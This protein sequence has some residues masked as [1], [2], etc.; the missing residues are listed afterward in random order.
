MLNNK[1][2]KNKE[3]K[4]KA[5]N[6]VKSLSVRVIAFVITVSF[7][8][9]SG[10][11]GLYAKM[12]SSDTL[13][14]TATENTGITAQLGEELKRKN[15][16]QP[17]K[18][19]KRIGILTG[20]GPAS[21][22]NEVIYS[23]IEEAQ[24]QGGIE[25]IA[26]WEG[27]KGLVDDKLAGQA[28]P[29]T[30]EEVEPE[31]HKG[32]TVI[33]TSRENPYDKKAAEKGL[34]LPEKLWANIQKLGLDALI[35]CGGDDSQGASYQLQQQHPDFLVIGLPKTMDNDIN[36][37]KDA[38]S[39]GF[40]TFVQAAA[41]ALERGKRDAQSTN[42]VLVTGIFG[43][44]A[45]HVAV[46]AAA[47]AKITRTLIPE[48]G[49]L[50]LE[51]L[52]QDVKE[53]Y[54]K[55]K[56][57]VV[58]VAE[59]VSINKYYK[60]NAAILDKAFA[61]DEHAMVAF[62]RAARGEK[63]DSYGNPYLEGAEIIIAAVLEANGLSISRAGKIDYLFRSEDVSPKDR[64]MCNLLGRAAVNNLIEGNNNR[65][66]YVDT[67]GALES[68]PFAKKVGGRTFDIEEHKEVYL[69]AN[70]ALL[71][72]YLNDGGSSE[73]PSEDSI[74]SAQP[75]LNF[76]NVAEVNNALRGILEVGEGGVRIIDDAR[77]RGEL[78]DKLVYDAT[79]NNDP[80][81]VKLCRQL[82]RDTASAQGAILSSL[83]S[84]YVAKAKDKRQYT[85]PAINI[86][87]MAYNTARPVFTSAVANNVGPFILEIAKSEIGY[88]AQR[89]A[90][91]TTSI[92]AAAIKEGY[93]GPVYLQGD[94]FQISAD[95]YYGNA[96]K[97]IEANPEKAKSDI[98][99]MIREAVAAGFY[100]I[101]LDMST[102][103]DWSKPTANE[104]QKNNY[105]E[106]AL[107]TAFVRDL[108]REFGLDK[109]GIVVN[110]G[111]E[112]GEIGM[113]LDKG[114]QLNSSVEDLRAFMNGY[115][116]ELKA[117]GQQIGYELKPVTKIAVQTG[118]KHGGV[119]DAQGK[120]TKAMVSFNTLAETGNVARE[121]FGLAGVVQHGAS[122]LP[123]DYFTVFAGKPVPEG[124]SVDETLLNEA[125]KTVLGTNPVAEV[126]LATA[127]QDTIMEHEQFP[128]ALLAQIWDYIL[129]KI[130][131]KE[132]EGKDPN[133]VFVDN[134]KNAWGSFK[135][136]L[137]NLPDDIQEAFRNSLEAQF[138]T[139]FINLGVRDSHPIIAQASLSQLII[140]DNTSYSESAVE[141][142]S[143]ANAL[144][145][146]KFAKAALVVSANA[147]F[148][149][150]GTLT[151][152][153]KVKENAGDLIKIAVWAKDEASL[154]KLKFM[155]LGEVADMISSD[156]V[157][158]VLSKLSK[159]EVAQNRIALLIS[160]QDTKNI[161]LDELK[162]RGINVLNL[163]NPEAEKLFINSM[164]LVIA[165]AVAGILQE[166]TEVSIKY[167]DFLQQN[168][169]NKVISEQ[170]YNT[171]VNLTSQIPEIPLV[172]VSEEKAKEVVG[173][174]IIY[175]ATT[176]QI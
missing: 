67:N 18:T 114:Q 63:M 13:R 94:H 11:V 165:R 71:P 93:R 58:L 131:A 113:G 173:A 97:G 70:Q 95:V 100:Q 30:L 120:V 82:I 126:H 102:L 176:N 167:K 104:Q 135:L 133:K 172:K 134:R 73:S 35:V 147:I 47:M 55:N 87:G 116:A 74:V 99:E 170:N 1:K 48:E 106:T 157:D 171:L 8:L 155:G 166:N 129:G 136:Q 141:F 105:L 78:I 51:Q 77:L 163:K 3:S 125:S 154:E 7:V 41:G 68:I 34:Q 66:L 10:P 90:E 81:V 145:G 164:P 60:N 98:K 19:I 33:R 127:Y 124:M 140:V 42:R 46:H 117:L 39:Y 65:I 23:V 84:L 118:T 152:L 175:Q 103:V 137:W 142:D 80:E 9:T 16:Q 85:V 43:R 76:A 138:N 75:M 146:T 107:L 112:I 160:A 123:P 121:E 169:D 162:A 101:D 148:E 143:F 151:V 59:G 2:I 21:G 89:P 5:L 111:G 36:L 132:K 108:E 14:S 31:R 153:K 168:L 161:N 92:L 37:P 96:K 119:R 27:W 83:Y 69:T 49:N 79:F 139:V 110:L 91:F 44:S 12:L 6:S 45:G 38:W 109:L 150:A 22:H 20:G 50:D 88:T 4:M 26:I 149:N 25:V 53:Y 130:P 144:K 86:R 122:T 115:L 56:Y 15:E 156:G 32:G 158:N 64:E 61:K 57:A 52:V 62:E 128:A 29:L 174:Q 24:K 54:N 72:K 17:H 159:E 40:D 28:R